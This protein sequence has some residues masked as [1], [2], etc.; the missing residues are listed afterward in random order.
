MSLIDPILDI[1]DS[2][3]SWFSSSVKQTMDTYCDVET[4]EDE[5]TLVNRDGSLL[6]II[7]VDGVMHLVG[8]EEFDYIHNGLCQNLQSVL[9]KPGH[10]VQFFFSYDR[11][12]AA[13]EITAMMRPAM[14]T[15]EQLRLD[16]DDLFKERIINISSYCAKESMYIALWTRPALLPKDRLKDS[17]KEK[18]KYIR[19][20]KLPSFKNSQNLIASVKELRNAHASF[21][22]S[23]MND[24]KTYKIHANLLEV[25][26]AVRAMRMSSDIDFTDERWRPYLPGDE[27]PIRE[28]QNKQFEMSGLLWPSLYRQLFP[29]DAEVLDLRTVRVGDRIYSSVFIDLFP[30]DIQTFVILFGRVLQTHIPWRMSFLIEGGGFGTLRYKAAI[31]GILSWTSSH[32]RLIN[33]AN[34]LLHEINV[35]SDDAVVKLRVALST[36][37]P[38]GDE[39]LLRS[40]AAEL[41][42]AVQSWGSCDV[43]EVSGDAYAGVVSS[44]LAITTQNVATASVAPLSDVVTMLPFTRPA[45]SWRQ[46]ALML[47]TPD[48]KPWPFQP[49]SSQQ[50]TWIDLMYARPGSGKSVLSNSINLALCLSPGI[51]RLPRIS[52][53]DIG[54]SSS[55]LVSLLREALPLEQRHLVAYHRMR[56]TPDYSIN[57]FDTQLGSRSPTPQERGF[58]VNFLTLLATPIGATKPYDGMADM[59]GLVVDELYKSLTDGVGPHVYTLNIEPVIDT[60]LNEINFIR[61]THTTWWEVT[62]ALFTAGFTHEAKLAQRHAVPLLAD[63]VSI[64]RTPAIEDLYGRVTAPTGEPIILAFARMISSA[65]REYPV[66]SQITQFDLGDSRIVSLDL[67]EVAKSGG[68]AADRQTAVMYMLARYILAKDYYLVDDNVNDM[69]EAY[70][71]Y[72]KERIANIRE[73]A[74]RIVYDEFHRTSKSQAVR[75]QVITDMREGRKWNVQIALISQS[76]DDFEKIMIEFATSTY[77]ME[78]G[79]NQAIN[80]TSEIFGLSDTARTALKNRV[81]GPRQDGATFLAIFAIKYGNNMQ[82]LTS[83]IGPIELWAF[84]TTTEDAMLRNKLY[85]ALGPKE[86]RRVLSSVFPAGSVKSIIEE[87]LAA[88]KE[89]SGFIQEVDE[90]SIINRLF[91]AVLQA[92]KDNPNFQRLPEW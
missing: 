92:Y 15:A 54:P 91:K 62:D 10:A 23:L 80:R 11:E 67:D 71:G 64:C 47:R 87:K 79:P 27:I 4:A 53:I 72:H 29:R 88:L 70:R 75:D 38:A 59:A 83:T 8:E 63:V 36:W 28:L 7:R 55:G 5:V 43:S 50:T 6:S 46:G 34:K 19:E 52:V 44:M 86:A 78:A 25:H 31:A 18:L 45:S 42:K 56:M 69:P 1:V 37:A 26:D 60:I 33:K 2:L 89:Q 21:G 68:D 22:R 17:H 13:E 41:A 74:K 39:P 82:L 12:K 81:H 32:N 3:M 57:P 24:L 66:L 76:V 48:G 16:L 90:D 61:D 20:K 85:Q 30:Q 77:I 51:R 65:V 58:I 35:G 40:R 73:D 9:S 14:Q 84:S 49:G